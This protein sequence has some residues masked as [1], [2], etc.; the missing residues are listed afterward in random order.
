MAGFEI[1]GSTREASSASEDSGFS[2]R[3]SAACL[4][5][6]GKAS[7]R[8]CSRSVRMAFICSRDASTTFV[9]LAS[10]QLHRRFTWLFSSCSSLAS[11]MPMEATDAPKNV[12]K[13]E[14]CSFCFRYITCVPLRVASLGVKPSVS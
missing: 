10:S 11:M 1:C 2:S 8:F 5:L 3:T 13:S 7:N 14:I 12:K 6:S 4:S 9:I